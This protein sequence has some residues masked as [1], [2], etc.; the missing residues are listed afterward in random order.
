M[1]RAVLLDVVK[2]STNSSKLAEAA[3]GEFIA[4]KKFAILISI[5][6]SMKKHQ[7]VCFNKAN[8]F[9]LQN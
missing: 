3:K 7:F 9:K 5:D 6:I 8:L 1:V 2:Q 4:S